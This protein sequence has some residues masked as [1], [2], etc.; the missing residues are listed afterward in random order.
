MNTKKVSMVVVLV[1]LAVSVTGL[2]ANR[3]VAQES[4]AG[5]GDVSSGGPERGMQGGRGAGFLRHGGGPFRPSDASVSA[6]SGK[7]VD[8]SCTFSFT[9]SG[10][11]SSASVDGTCMNRPSVAS[12]STDTVLS[13]VP[14]RKNSGKE[15]QSSGVRGDGAIN[16]QTRLQRAQQM[17]TQKVAQISNIE[18]RIGKIITFLA[19]KGVD[20]TTLSGELATFTAKANELLSRIDAYIAVL[21]TNGSSATDITSAFANVKTS[22]ADMRTYFHDTLRAAIGKAVSSLNE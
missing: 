12:G 4:G 7:S 6:C 5:A 15:G 3:V 20:T 17:K 16:G 1:V 11:G 8:D 9:G 21:N 22:G 14:T 10:S 19:S 2:V 13:C 18:D